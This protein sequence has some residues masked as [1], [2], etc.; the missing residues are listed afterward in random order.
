MRHVSFVYSYFANAHD[1]DNARKPGEAGMV[2]STDQIGTVTSILGDLC[3]QFSTGNPELV[4]LG[5]LEVVE[6]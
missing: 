5:S 3:L 2:A 4:V 1:L 6:T